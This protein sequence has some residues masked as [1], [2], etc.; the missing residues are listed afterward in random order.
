MKYRS[1]YPAKLRGSDKDL[2]EGE[3]YIKKLYISTQGE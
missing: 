2:T 1:N 3:Q